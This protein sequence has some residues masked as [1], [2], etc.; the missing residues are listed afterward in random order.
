MES[1]TLLNKSFFKERFSR[2]AITRGIKRVLLQVVQAREF[3]LILLLILIGC[4]LH[5]YSGGFLSNFKGAM[6]VAIKKGQLFTYLEVTSRFL[7]SIDN[8]RFFTEANLRAVGLGFSTSAIIVF[9]MT[10]ALVSG[11]FDLS[12]GSVYALG[13]VVVA[14]SLEKDYSITE[15][16]LRGVGIGLLAGLVNG[17]L[18]TWGQINP[19]ITTLGMLGMARG[20]GLVL[21]KGTPVSIQNRHF[22]DFVQRYGQGEAWGIPNLIIV[23]V[24]VI[25][26]GD[27][28]MRNASLFRQIYYVGGN[29]EAARLSGINVRRVKIG[30]YMLSGMLAAL[31]GVLSVSRFTVADPGAAS[32]EELRVIAACIIGGCS[33]RGGKGTVL[34][35]L[36]GLIFVAL[37]NNG[38]VLTRVPVYYQQLSM[39]IVLL[40]AVGLDTVSQH[41]REIKTAL[42]LA[43]RKFRKQVVQL[44][45][46]SARMLTKGLATLR[47]FREARSRGNKAG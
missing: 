38:M 40:L 36:L 39:G 37:I 8:G 7:T 45:S 9:G 19:F 31:A 47:Q 17:L 35:G 30:V 6:E 27:I 33:L 12:V 15:A 21:T 32:G 22:P 5:L 43:P 14:I 1:S 28:L 29:E 23:G 13:G 11:G 26:I 16:M 44:R 25:I 2:Q 46:N 24:G 34:G 18:I 20:L 41:W 3:F 4:F 10:A 42:R